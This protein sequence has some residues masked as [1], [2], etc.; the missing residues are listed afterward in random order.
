VGNN[1][2]YRTY[3]LSQENTVQH[4]TYR[5]F[6]LRSS[7]WML[8]KLL[9]GMLQS[10]QLFTD[11]LQ[12]IQTVRECFGRRSVRI[13]HDAEIVRFTALNSLYSDELWVSGS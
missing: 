5:L 3:A 10:K 7:L 11:R 13:E 4:R 2:V 6:L 1:A 12:F 8:L 9:Q